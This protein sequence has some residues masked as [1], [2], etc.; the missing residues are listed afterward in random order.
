M[1]LSDFGLDRR[2]LKERF[3]KRPGR[4]HIRFDHPL[5]HQ[6]VDI[7]LIPRREG[8]AGGRVRAGAQRVPTVL[9]FEDQ[10][11]LEEALISFQA[12]TGIAGQ[13]LHQDCDQ[14]FRVEINQ[15]R[16]GRQAESRDQLLGWDRVLQGGQSE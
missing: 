11:L 15:P 6:L 9:R 7:G 16:L 4:N 1:T 5:Q 12:A 10:A 2:P 8:A 14:A 3:G 13:V